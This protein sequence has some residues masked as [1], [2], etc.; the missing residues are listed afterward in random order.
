MQDKPIYP[1][2]PNPEIPAQSEFYDFAKQHAQHSDDSSA[3]VSMYRCCTIA[4][5]QFLDTMDQA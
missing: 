4:A 5:T 2:T 1:N 3:R